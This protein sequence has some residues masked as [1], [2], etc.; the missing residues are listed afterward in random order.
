MDKILVV[1]D[2]PDITLLLERFLSK[3]H[4]DVTITSSGKDAIRKIQNEKYN[5]AL[6]DFRLPDL[7]G[8]ELLSFAR[9]I[10]PDLQIV[11][12]T[13]YSDVKVAINCIKAG[14]FDYVTKPLHHEEIL[15]L[16]KKALA[17]GP[18]QKTSA[19]SSSTKATKKKTKKSEVNA[20]PSFIEGKSDAS[21]HIS[22][23][24][25]LVA[26]TDMSVIIT[27]ETGTGKEIAA[28][29]IHASSKRSEE[30]FVAIDCGALPKNLAGSELFGHKKGSFTGALQDK[31]GSFEIAKGGTLFL[32]EVGN[33][34]Y[35]N[36]V[37]L[38]RVLQEKTIRRIGDNKNIKTD[39]RILAATN[40]NIE[41]LVRDGKFREDL[42]HRLCEF[43]IEL[44]PLRQRKED[45][46]TF[47]YHFLDQASQELNKS[48][49][50][51]SDDAENSLQQYYWHGNLRELGNVIKRAL[52]L[53]EHDFIGINAL[54]PEITIGESQV[55]QEDQSSFLKLSGQSKTLKDIVQ[56]A[57][58]LAIQQALEETNFNKTKTAQILDVDRKTLYNK[59]N[60]YN[61]SFARPS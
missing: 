35:E 25:K 24:V 55:A 47:T 54:P 13:G 38:L 18:N 42:Y 9:K 31:K 21:K 12:I 15:H 30:S 52:L 43:K 49:S 48:T 56:E 1:D 60:A 26:P 11:I 5:L 28:R 14:A 8:M 36:Q 45:I 50:G 19:S 10:D 58:K 20:Q 3:H 17:A 22:K 32:D 40:E 2:D 7:D 57:E 53:S 41:V 29:R 33:L 44:L 37:K 34:S 59:M 39:V 4:F 27:G 46:L 23:L 6:V 61:I 16:V 51:F